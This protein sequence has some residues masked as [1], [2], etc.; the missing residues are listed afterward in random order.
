MSGIDLNRGV[1][2]R[3]H[4]AGMQICMYHDNP[5]VFYD[6]RGLMVKNELAKAAGF[7]VDE[8]V[9]QREKNL[10][11]EEYRKRVDAEFESDEDKLAAAASKGSMVVKS[12]GG[13]A[14]AVFDG[15]ERI[16]SVPLTL[17]EAENLVD[18]LQGERDAGDTS[19]DAAEATE[20]SQAGAGAKEPRGAAKGAP[21][22]QEDGAGEALI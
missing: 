22:P 11:I 14:F 8:L 4:P 15:D 3:N 19:D 18:G 6:E 10:R 21:R 1:I 9:R 2:K 20:G 17:E 13:G 16:T 7:R 5:G 12:I